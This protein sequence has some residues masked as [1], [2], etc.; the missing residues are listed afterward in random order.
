MAEPFGIVPEGFNTPAL[1]DL[2]TGFQDQQLTGISPNLDMQATALIGNLNG[3]YGQALADAWLVL[4][5]IY[6]GMDP[7]VAADDQLTSLCLITGTLR[8][9]ATATVCNAC[10]TTVGAGF[11]AAA[12]TM[13]AAIVGN[14][15]AV[16]TNE[17]AV[18]NPSGSP[19]TLPVDFKAIA[20]GP[21]QC[22]TG[23]LTVISQPL[24]GWTAI[25]NPTDGVVGT[26]IQGDPSLRLLRQQELAASGSSTADAIRADVLENLQP[27]TTTTDTISCTVLSNDTDVPDANGL[28]P[29][30]IEVIAYQPGA[31]SADDQALADLI[32][33]A[34]AAG[35][36]TNGLAFKSVTDSQ[37]VVQTVSY[38][39]PTP[40]TFHVAITVVVDPETF[41][42]DG[43]TQVANALL[44]YA[45]LEYD[46]GIEVRV[47]PLSGSVF[48]SPLDATIGVPGVVDITAFAVDIN[49]PPVNT[50]NIGIPIRSVAAFDSSRIVVVA[51]NE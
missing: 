17:E 24:T 51:V 31:D 5:A 22:L 43:L 50:A 12:G 16:F 23:T 37:G 40:M 28:P 49:F 38:T 8:G 41:P 39:R 4:A 6:G 1:E 27:P 10:S 42:L 20:T 9:G 36:G 34:K 45:Q 44:N 2:V 33:N 18:S 3:I 26:N 32:W 35:I 25:T 47:R 7:D 13:F 30:S 46:P 19:V 14:P 11:T 29:H 21:Q 15:A 48:P